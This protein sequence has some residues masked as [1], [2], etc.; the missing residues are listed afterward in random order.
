MVR[1]RRPSVPSCRNTSGAEL[2]CRSACSATTVPPGRSSRAATTSSDPHRV[3]PVGTG[4]QRERRVVAGH[5]G[6][7]DDRADGDVGRV[8]H[9]DVDAAVEVGEGVGHVTESQ[10][11]AGP[12]AVARRPGE[13]VGVGLDG[14]H[15]RARHLG[16]HGQRDRTRP[17]AQVDHDRPRVAGSRPRARLDGGLSHQ[18]RLRSRHEDTRPDGELEMAEERPAGDVLQRL[19]GGTPVDVRRKRPGRVPERRHRPQRAPVDAERVRGQLLG[20]E[21]RRGHAGGGEPVGGL[22]RQRARRH[23]R[24]RHWLA[25]ANLAEVSAST[26]A[27]TTAS[28]SP[29]STASRLCALKLTRW[30][31]MRF[32]GK[33]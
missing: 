6:V 18:L 20:V 19:P 26:S 22:A 8:A 28:R 2:P 13:G 3:Q 11:D 25:A 24:R 4:P 30:S 17:R 1:V 21:P 15:P 23:R 27:C 9:D 14:V 33:L 10:V 31:E 29:S 12:G 16:G 7:A 5:L 32:S